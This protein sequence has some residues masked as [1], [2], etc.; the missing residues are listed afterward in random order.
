[1]KLGLAMEEY[2][3]LQTHLNLRRDLT[4]SL[5]KMS[6]TTSSGRSS[7]CFVLRRTIA[8]RSFFPLGHFSTEETG[9]MLTV[10]QY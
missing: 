5:A 8:P 7:S 10:K 6:N 1:M 4:G 9:C 3:G 2:Q